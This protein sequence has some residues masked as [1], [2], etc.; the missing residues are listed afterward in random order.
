M[1]IKKF[2]NKKYTIIAIVLAVVVAVGFLIFGG[3][4]GGV[5]QV[6]VERKDIVQ[7]VLAAGK[8][9][10]IDS[11]EL[12]FEKSGRV[13]GAYVDVGTRVKAGQALVELD[14]SDL[15]AD[16]LKAQA[17]LAEEN[18][19][20]VTNNIAVS[21]ATANAMAVI[22]DSYTKADNVIRASIDQFFDDP[23]G[24]NANFRP[25]TQNSVGT[26]FYFYV[27]YKTKVNINDNRSVITKKFVLWNTQIDEMTV[28]NV[29]ELL[30]KSEEYLNIV[31]TLV[32]T[33]STVIFT[34]VSPDSNNIA[35]V[36]G[37]KTDVSTARTTINTALSNIIS[38]REKLNNARAGE[39]S[40][41]T[42]TDSVSAQG[43]RKLQIQAQIKNIQSQ[44]AKTKMQAPFD[45]IVTKQDVEK[46]EIVGAGTTI[47]SI[48]SDNKLEIES[49]ISEVNIGKITIGNTVE[50]TLDAYP[51]E[52]WSGTV[53]YIDPGET[54]VDGVVNYKVKVAILNP[55]SKIKSGLT[56]NLNIETAKKS[57]ALVVPLY[58]VAT[59]SGGS[60][61]KKVSGDT[62]EEVLVNLGIVGQDGSVEIIS[63]LNEGD[64]VEVGK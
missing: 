43:A 60:Y 39:T 25:S 44:I 40:L 38:A 55:D 11:V 46:G 34:L 51:G 35:N 19:V 12:G 42:N 52:S 15:Q 4:N 13:V 20:G 61:V 54:I 32:D 7:S 62:S 14:N 21:D 48:I 49:N 8:T 16:L 5:T 17:D 9:K 45:G 2:I 28:S 50:I 63:G 1:N 26:N 37:Y 31:K 23:E 22:S 36:S 57:G 56:A 18:A 59:K 24:D 64:K 30:N 53:S 47:V 58:A 33:V 29:D 6:G 10:A 3:G 41:S 27:D